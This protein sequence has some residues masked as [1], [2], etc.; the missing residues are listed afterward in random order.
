MEM[1]TQTALCLLATSVVLQAQPLSV[2]ITQNPTNVHDF[3]LD[4]LNMQ[5]GGT[6]GIGAKNMP[7]PDPFDI[8]SL[9]S[10]FNAEAPAMRFE[11]T[12]AFPQRT[13]IAADLNDYVGASVRIASPA[14]E[15]ILAG[16]VPVQV[17]VAD[18]LPL[19]TVEVF[20]GE[21]LVGV[22]LPRQ[23]GAMNLPSYRFPNGE[24]QIWVRV[25]NEG[26][27]VDTDGDGLP[28]SPTTFA[29]WGSV[30]VTFSNEVYMENFSPLYSAYGLSYFA[31]A[32]HDYTFEVFRLNGE[33]LHTQ[34]GVIIGSVSPQWNFTDLLG[35]PVNDS[36]YVF[37]LTATPQGGAAPPPPPPPSPSPTNSPPPPPPPGGQ[38]QSFQGSSNGELLLIQGGAVLPSIDAPRSNLTA[39]DL[40]DI[41]V[42]IAAMKPGVP[43][44]LPPSPP[45]PPKLP[46]GYVATMSGPNGLAAAGAKV[47]TTTNFFDKGVTVGKYVISYGESPYGTVNDWYEIMSD[48]VSYRVNVAAF[49]DSDII[50][51]NRETH[52]TVRADFTA[53]PYAIKRATQTNDTA[54][55]AAAVSDAT[56]GSWLF[57]GHS[58]T[59]SII[60]G[61]DGYLTAFLSAQQIAALLGN[62]FSQLVGTNLFYNR[63]LFST[64]ITGCSAV[65]GALPI[66]T[67]TPPGVTQVENPLIKKSAFLGFTKRSLSGETKTQWIN[68]IHAEWLDGNAYD[69]TLSAAEAIATIYHPDVQPWGP[70]ILGYYLLIYNG[71]G[72]W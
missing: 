15:S 72:S 31:T 52:S 25:V 3:F 54:L 53:A 20:V 5:V 21:T 35:N 70:T 6:Y 9:I 32:P 19:L 29:S 60:H 30:S 36:G 49:F 67:G 10:V 40:A 7:S 61:I 65:N 66:A 46:P 17:V 24:Q 22:I 48:V 58:G 63:R 28:D 11:A 27:D 47:I 59:N 26:I 43:P 23:G 55:L 62:T 69:T 33:L 51:E 13:F 56:T 16:D 18:I 14:P 50:G 41:L 12:A 42:R 57:S 34:S 64:F 37:S 1:K 71:F 4:V 8:W 68:R 39:D 44:P 2:A 38:Q 45:W